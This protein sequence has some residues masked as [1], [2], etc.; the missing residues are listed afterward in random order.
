M[1]PTGLGIMGCFTAHAPDELSAATRSDGFGS[2]AHAVAYVAGGNSQ[3]ATRH[4][5]APDRS[6]H[7]YCSDN[8]TFYNICDGSDRYTVRTSSLKLGHV[9]ECFI[10]GRSR[11][12]FVH[13][14][15]RS[16]ERDVGCHSL[17]SNDASH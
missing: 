8:I 5:S 6:R 7:A 2:V 13:E 4:Y 9:K 16:G 3:K 10:E 14:S 15:R 11:G 12:H 17:S 1:L